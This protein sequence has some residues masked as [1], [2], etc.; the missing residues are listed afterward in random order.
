MTE[1]Y[2]I[3]SK[4]QNQINK[5]ENVAITDLRGKHCQHFGKSK[6]RT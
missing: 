3:V 5:I 6:T 1:L 4:I 2:K